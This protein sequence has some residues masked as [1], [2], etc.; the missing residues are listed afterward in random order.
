MFFFLFVTNKIILVDGQWGEWKSS[1]QCSRTCGGGSQYQARRCD[2]PAP[3]NGGD[4]CPGDPVR[5][6][7]CSQHQCK[8]VS[9]DSFRLYY[10][11]QVPWMDPGAPGDPGAS[12]ARA[13]TEEPRDGCETVLPGTGVRGRLRRS[14]S[15]TRTAVRPSLSGHHGVSV[16][17]SVNTQPVTLK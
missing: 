13:V 4:D 5:Q 9:I 1:G 12:V 11:P 8:L 6:R 16:L 7:S 3:A 10:P 17:R 2:S 14:W 15:V